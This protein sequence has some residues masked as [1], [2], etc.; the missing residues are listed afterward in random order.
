MF[1]GRLWLRGTLEVFDG[2]RRL[3]R[4]DV[5]NTGATAVLNVLF[6]YLPAVPSQGKWE[7]L[8]PALALFV[9]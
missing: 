1:N 6:P 2:G 5:V 3:S 7:K 8:R 9:K 4:E